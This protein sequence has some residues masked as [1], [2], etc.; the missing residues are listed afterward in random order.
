MKRIL[1]Y[2][3]IYTVQN[4]QNMLDQPGVEPMKMKRSEFLDAKHIRL[5]LF[6]CHNTCD[7]ISDLHSS[8]IQCDRSASA[9]SRDF[10]GRL[11]GQILT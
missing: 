6:V 1:I 5:V 3:L 7:V 11:R 8:H 4:K 9:I 10:V 2:G